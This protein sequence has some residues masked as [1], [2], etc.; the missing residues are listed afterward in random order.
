MKRLL[1]TASAAALMLG[2]A[3]C[4]KTE[5]NAQTAEAPATE[6]TQTASNSAD[7]MYG[8]E[9]MD[10]S[11]NDEMG[12]KK[13]VTRIAYVPATG[14]MMAS[15]LIDEDVYDAN[16]EEIGEIADIMISGDDTQPTLIIRDGVAGAL[17][18]V[19]F[20]QATITWDEEK[21]PIA[22][23]T[24]TDE[25]LDSMPEFEQ[26][27][28]NDYRLASELMG[29]NASLAFNDKEVRITDF[30]MAKDGTLKY[31]VVADGVVDALTSDRYLVNPD[32]ITIAQGDS[33]GEIVL[34]L[35]SEEYADAPGI[36]LT[37]D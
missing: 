24:V 22:T 29:T 28:L 34:D 8:G 30:I 19:T 6:T 23:L 27:G 4:S 3:A 13:D 36:E 14:E 21:E 12:A 16:G 32:V 1:I 18:P 2:A 33:D 25:T 7:A 35:T 5:T 20:D 11:A 26:E 31:A 15:D 10:A 17:H 37:D 9:V